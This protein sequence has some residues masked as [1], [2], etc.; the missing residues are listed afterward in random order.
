MPL[1][2]GG[3]FLLRRNC[4]VAFDMT[5]PIPTI[6]LP[7]VHIS[8]WNAINTRTA[9]GLFVYR[10]MQ[11]IGLLELPDYGGGDLD[12]SQ[13]KEALLEAVS[14]Q[15]PLA[16]L[17]LFLGVVSLEDFIRD[18]ATRLADNRSCV[19]KFPKLA[20]LRAKSIN[21]PPD[22]MFK[23]LDSDPAGILDPE[24]INEAFKIAIG[25]EPLPAAEFWHLRDLALLRHTVAH[26]AGVIRQ[27]DLPRFAHFIVVP[28]RAINPPPDFVKA[29]LL[30]LYKLGRDIE[31]S[32]RSA[33][34]AGF[35]AA[36]GA[37]WSQHLST[38][39]VEL[40]ELFAFFGYLE[41]AKVAVGYSEPGSIRRQ[42]QEADALRIRTLLLQRCVATLTAEFGP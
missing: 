32:V 38:E 23:R 11:A 13:R 19:T 20:N 8:E 18:L 30:Y 5:M 7:E 26:H 37:G 29:E 27:V 14:F 36:E 17:A 10:Q 25:V 9:S 42:Q 16:A 35:I 39:M 21:R 31:V 28:G 40:I 34:F 6:P 15:K 3:G 2:K 12:A 1:P 24:A 22:K 4:M 41:T 33:V